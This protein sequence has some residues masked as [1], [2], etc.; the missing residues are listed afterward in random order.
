MYRLPFLITIVLVI[1]IGGLYLV[2]MKVGLLGF[3]TTKVTRKD[4]IDN[5]Q[6]N[7]KEILSLVRYFDSLQPKNRG[8]LFRL[9]KSDEKIT[10][11]LFNSDGVISPD[12]PNLGATNV[13]IGSPQ[14][15][16]LL[17]SIGWTVSIV[18]TLQQKLKSINCKFINPGNPT[19][20]RYGSTN[21]GSFNYYIYKSEL[22]DSS[23]RYFNQI[24][25][26]VINKRVVI[27]FKSIL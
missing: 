6:F 20:L 3:S 19:E 14:M 12:R 2:A 9:G 26:T 22:S 25:D 17:D 21:T 8:V 1:I 16:T 10:I 18:K 11:G 24:G 5:F 27:Q 15:S 23:I 7:E 4:A 13:R